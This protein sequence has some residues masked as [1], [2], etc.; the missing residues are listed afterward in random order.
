MSQLIFINLFIDNN[1]DDEKVIDQIY[2][3]KLNSSA[4]ILDS[5]QNWGVYE[6]VPGDSAI[7]VQK[8][9]PSFRE[10]LAD[11]LDLADEIFESDLSHLKNVTSFHFVGISQTEQNIISRFPSV[12]NNYLSEASYKNLNSKITLYEIAKD[13][14]I[15]FPESSIVKLKDFKELEKSSSSYVLKYINS[16]GGRG[17]FIINESTKNLV[18]FIDRQLEE[19]S[20]DLQFLKQEYVEIKSHFYTLAN[21]N[22]SSSEVSGFKIIYDKHKNSKLHIYEDAISEDRIK[23]AEKIA[24]SLRALGYSG[25]FGFDGFESTNGDIYP[26]VDLNVRYDK[27]RMILNLAKKFNIHHNYFEFRRERFHSKSYKTFEQY[28]SSRID[29]LNEINKKYDNRFYL[30]PVL[31]SN[32]FKAEEQSDMVEI[33]FFTGHNSSNQTG[34][35]AWITEIY[36]WMGIPASLT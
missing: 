32:F 15:N 6:G 29:D 16:A 26:A 23:A 21:T 13:N 24:S 25:V 19:K 12:K 33:S 30:L 27:S 35:Q 22:Y 34:F 5:Y 8:F 1:W 11:K 2:S 3:V 36:N 4:E 20:K 18:S 28:W 7:V 14:E 17:V 9:D 10:F 31:F